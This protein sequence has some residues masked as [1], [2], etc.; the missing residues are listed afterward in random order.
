M[1]DN[2]V[3]PSRLAGNRGSHK[4]KQA[5]KTEYRNDREDREK[6]IARHKKQP[7][8]IRQQEED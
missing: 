4:S 3:K 5:K 2:E 8:W 6:P 1:N 7:K